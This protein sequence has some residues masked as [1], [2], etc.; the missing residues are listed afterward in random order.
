MWFISIQK[1]GG[2]GFIP[3]VFMIPTL[4]NCNI[5]YKWS[6]VCNM[7]T[8][9]FATRWYKCMNYK[10]SISNLD[11]LYSWL[12]VWF[13]KFFLIFS[14]VSLLTWFGSL[15]HVDLPREFEWTYAI[16]LALFK[17][18]YRTICCIRIQVNK[19]TFEEIIDATNSV[20]ITRIY[21]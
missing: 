15:L 21:Y 19:H 10:F 9:S 3:R 8:K 14:L 13:V 20:G 16:S 5:N 6:F 11:T 2:G 12:V 1:G 4:T 17:A 7:H 18:L